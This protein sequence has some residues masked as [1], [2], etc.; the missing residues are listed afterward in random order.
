MINKD[1]LFKCLPM[2]T[3]FKYRSEL[4]TQLKILKLTPK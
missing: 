3:N 1:S 2:I 4:K